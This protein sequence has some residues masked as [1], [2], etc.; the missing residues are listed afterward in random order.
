MIYVASRAS[1]PERPSL[2]KRLRA[3]GWPITST[4]IDEAG[5]GETADLNELWTR[6]EAEIRAASCL[7]LYAE[8]N[9]FP[10]KGAF[11]E[12]GMAIGMGKPVAVVLDFVPEAHNCAPIGSWI[13]HPLVS[14]HATVEEARQFLEHIVARGGKENKQ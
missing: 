4:W 9:D 5:V 12:C 2:W 14:V 1:V 3:E 11:I 13:K 10:L 8:Y 7:I 6:I